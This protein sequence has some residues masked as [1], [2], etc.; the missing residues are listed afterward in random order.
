VS[1]PGKGKRF[2]CSLKRPEGSGSL[3]AVHSVYTKA[4]FSVLKRLEHEAD[5]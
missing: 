2:F 4:S 5:H 3:R 1:I